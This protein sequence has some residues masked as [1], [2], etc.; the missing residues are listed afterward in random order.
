MIC[1]LTFM[2]KIEF[3]V[4]G[5]LPQL[6]APL[7]RSESCGVNSPSPQTA[8]MVICPLPF[9]PRTFLCTVP[10]YLVLSA[11]VSFYCAYKIHTCQP[12][13]VHNADR[14]ALEHFAHLNFDC[15]AET[16]Q[17]RRK[18]GCLL[19]PPTPRGGTT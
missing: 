9:S 11:R 12:R 17:D 5:W 10:I 4:K 18:Y 14:K 2:Q 8:C 13:A 3:F 1:T 7:N 15:T 6:L 16:S 19:S